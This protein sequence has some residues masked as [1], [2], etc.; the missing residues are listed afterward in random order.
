MGGDLVELAARVDA[1]ARENADLLLQ[2]GRDERRFRRLARAVWR[3][4]EAE[5]RRLAGEL[6]DGVGQTLTALKIRLER[7]GGAAPA[8]EVAAGL[9]EA[10]A[11]AGEALAETRLLSHLL[12]PRVLD[13]LGLL[14][15]LRWLGRTLAGGGLEVGLAV[16]GLD[17]DERL[18]AEVETVLFRVAQEA[19]ANVARHA[20]VPRA[21]LEL[22]RDGGRLRLRV[23]DAGRGFDPAAAA[24]AAEGAGLAGIRDRVEA[25]GGRLVVDSAPGR[26][27][28]LVVTLPAEGEAP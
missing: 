3:V 22:T 14:P 6:H 17:D 2:L 20:C 21:R 7:L 11:L 26:G 1:L 27:T 19:L 4:E 25:F 18:P 15:A 12:R 23:E 16:R 13:D 10:V 5:R 9:A 24:A 8:A 28:A